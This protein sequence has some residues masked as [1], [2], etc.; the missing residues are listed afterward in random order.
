M[1]STPI[2]AWFAS[3][4]QRYE[5]LAAPAPRQNPQTTSRPG[6]DLHALYLNQQLLPGWVSN[7]PTAIHILHL[8]GPLAWHDFPERSLDN[9]SP[10]PVIPYAAIAAAYLIR[11]DEG[12]VSVGR[13]RRHLIR[14]P[15]LIWLCGFPLA[16]APSDPLGFDPQASLP[17]ARHLTR[18]LRQMPNHVLQFLLDSTVTLIDQAA[19]SQ[20]LLL[21]DAIAID[22]KHI[23]AWVKENNPKTFVSD[24]FDKTKQ[25]KGDPDCRLG[26][27][28]RHN[29]LAPGTDAAPPTPTKEAK[30]PAQVDAGEYYWGYAS[31]VVVARLEKGTHCLGEFVL[32]ELTQSFDQADISYFLP[33]MAQVERRL[34]RKPRFGALDAAFD[35]F[36]VYDYFHQAG[37]FAAVPFADRP[38][39][40]KQF[41][42]DGLP[43]CL[44]GLPMPRKGVFFKRSHCLVPHECARYACPL[45]HPKPNGQPCPINHK[46]WA[47]KGC[48]TTLPTSPGSLARHQLDRNDSAYKDI[49]RLRSADERINSQAVLLGIE[50]PKLR[51][52]QA[53]TNL[54]T[55]TYVLINLRAF[56]RLGQPQPDDLNHA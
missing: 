48:I 24:R 25:P 16:P 45:L 26:C 15:E 38:D 33:L 51:N 54:N 35:A 12:L 22:T 2:V 10:L 37:G 18:L 50:R 36:Y 49:Y 46:N 52:G 29:R 53:I 41:S 5:A 19:A 55:L 39:H 21:G 44:A 7:S 13:L 4:H 23:L 27:K 8:L 14:H 42:P 20:D 40:R 30:P 47:K 9:P 11:L 34:G 43:L 28:Q 6:C 17:T 3:L 1:F 31:G 56:Q 32:A